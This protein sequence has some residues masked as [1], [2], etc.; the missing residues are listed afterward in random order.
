MKLK[1]YFFAFS[2][3]FFSCDNIKKDTVSIIN[4]KDLKLI[5]NEKS[6]VSNQINVLQKE[7]K[8]LNDVIFDLDEN[9]KLPLV[10]NFKVTSAPFKHYIEVQ[11]SIDS[12]KNLKLYPEIP[13]I[14]K[15]IYV[16]EGQKVSK[17]MVLVE[18]SN[19]GIIAQIEQ[20]KLQVKLAGTIYERQLSLWKEKIGSEVQFLQ[21]ETNYL[22]LKKNIDQLK[23]QISKSKIIAPFDG[24]IDELIADP[25][26][27]VSPGITPVLRIINLDEVKV[28][29]EIPETHISKIKINSEVFIYTPVLSST[30]VS[31]ISTVGN[32]INPNNRNFRIEVVLKNNEYDFKPN[33]TVKVSINDYK[34]PNA[35]LVSQKNIIENSANEFYV[36]KLEPLDVSQHKFTAIKTFVKLGK[37]SNNK[38]EVLEGLN[39]GDLIVEDGIRLV[40]DKQIVKSI[41]Y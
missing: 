36:F 38:I 14:I 33:M 34:N 39:S 24:V 10:T 9:Q 29:A 35:L 32:I 41:N 6:V 21:A 23:F 16:K 27:N 26:S 13:G 17:G 40:T 12:D 3:V 2:L 22:S 1:I 31:K 28:K 4:S 25:G 30:V 11:G 7:L 19:E 20:M 37:I 15:S 5:Q 8:I 18:L